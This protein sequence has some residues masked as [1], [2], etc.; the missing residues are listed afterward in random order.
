MTSHALTPLTNMQPI[1]LGRVEDQYTSAAIEARAL[2]EHLEHTVRH[3][4][5][6]RWDQAEEFQRRSIESLWRMFQAI[7]GAI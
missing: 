6:R 5:G 2:A 3:L 7:D 4:R 1:D